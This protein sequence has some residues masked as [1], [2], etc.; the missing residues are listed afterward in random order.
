MASKT[1][2]CNLAL[3]RMGVSQSLTNV[4]TD[5]TRE[6]LSCL[7]VFDKERDYVLRDFPWQR[8]R[9]FATPSLATSFSNPANTDWVYAYRMPADALFIRRILTSNGRQEINPPAFALGRDP[10]F[11]TAAAW[12]S[13]T[14]YVVGN[15]VTLSGVVYEC[16]QANTN[17]S[18]PSGSYWRVVVNANVIFTD[19]AS[20]TFEY[21]AQITDP[22]QWEAEFVSMLAWR[23]AAELS[24]SLSRTQDFAKTCLEMYVQEKQAAQTRANL[25]SQ[26]DTPVDLTDA[27]TQEIVN[28][29]LLRLGVTR[30]TAPKG[31]AE[32]LS[33]ARFA[34]IA[35]LRE[36]DFVLRDFPWP[37][38]TA[39][40]DPVLFAGDQNAPF[41]KDW[42]FAYQ[43]PSDCF[44][45]R[46]VINPLERPDYR[47][48]RQY[49]W[50]GDAM[51]P[52]PFSLLSGAFGTIL[53]GSSN[54]QNNDTVTI[55]GQV[56]TFK[57]A[58]T[59]STGNANEVLIGPD[60]GTTSL[61]LAEAING[62]P[63]AGV[64]FGL[65]TVANTGVVAT[66]DGQITNPPASPTLV[67]STLTVSG[68]NGTSVNWST[69]DT[70]NIT[71]NP[72]ASLFTGRLILCNEGSPITIEYT[73]KL[74]SNAEFDGYD[75]T[76]SS[77]LAWRLGATLAPS[78][79]NPGNDPKLM[80][81]VLQK[82]QGMLAMYQME[83]TLAQRAALMEAQGQEPLEA[84]WI[85][86]R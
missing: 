33:E 3:M 66:V 75:R 12:N 72:S 44:Y 18:P 13:G 17:I 4:D 48:K 60:N 68:L 81:V 78:R 32:Y 15:M 10:A 23:L 40:A 2:V 53:I 55:N 58:L 26:K 43:F 5:G 16:I 41:S 52:V 22:T 24:L 61:H 37:W 79:L 71:L 21:T 51:W 86:S 76:F 64:D 54:A 31:S 29:A 67:G 63:N 25:E 46:R 27:T 82:A 85:R 9:A 11:G 28:F 8:A 47:R 56:Y 74:A 50:G 6:A 7:V 39:Y 42:I 77:M 73:R 49:Q 45:V 1:D 20:A 36:R 70:T 30:D 35:Y 84:E 34:K 80:Q 59:G 62:G 65:P 57:A 38:L 83:K 19:T 69:S 14:A